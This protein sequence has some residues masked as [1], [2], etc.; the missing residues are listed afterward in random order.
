MTPTN[1]QSLERDEAHNHQ[2]ADQDEQ[3]LEVHIRLLLLLLSVLPVPRSRSGVGMSSSVPAMKRMAVAVSVREPGR[4]AIG[5]GVREPMH[6]EAEQ[7]EQAPERCREGV[8]PPPRV[9]QRDAPAHEPRVRVGVGEVGVGVGLRSCGRPL[10]SW[11]VGDVCPGDVLGPWVNTVLA[12]AVQG[13]ELVLLDDSLAHGALGGVRVDAQPFVKAWPAE[14]VPAE[15]HDR[16]LWQLEAYVAL[17]ATPSISAT[18]A[19]AC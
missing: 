5:G 6:L 18:A 19:A 7:R 12:T 3:R 8:V 11:T 9:C 15:C 10:S 2:N 1:R 4:L 14:E 13:D 16:L 17:E